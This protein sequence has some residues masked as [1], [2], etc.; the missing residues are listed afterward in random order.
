[1]AA[2]TSRRLHTAKKRTLGYTQKHP[3]RLPRCDR[4]HARPANFENFAYFSSTY[5]P[6]SV[7]AITRFIRMN[8]TS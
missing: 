1:M 5:C 3:K 7:K 4:A 2:P 8:I 6:P